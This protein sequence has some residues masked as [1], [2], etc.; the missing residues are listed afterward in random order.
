MGAT[1]SRIAY[2]SILSVSG[3]NPVVSVSAA[4]MFLGVFLMPL[5]IR[6]RRL[7]PRLTALVLIAVI[8]TMAGC[9]G[10]SGF[11]PAG[12]QRAVASDGSLSG[13]VKLSTIKVGSG[14]AR[15][16]SVQTLTALTFGRSSQNVRAE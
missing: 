3:L 16:S 8:L 11:V 4:M 15:Q 14:D 2:A 9:E 13:P 7:A 5:G 6:R 1:V 12:I 10:G